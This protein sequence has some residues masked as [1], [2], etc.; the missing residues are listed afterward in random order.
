M[1]LESTEGASSGIV[2][3]KK[4]QITKGLKDLAKSLI[5]ESGG[6]PLVGKEEREQSGRKTL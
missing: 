3:W 2:L 4:W 5:S 1:N 6:T